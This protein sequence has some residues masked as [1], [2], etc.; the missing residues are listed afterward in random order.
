MWYPGTQVTRR[1]ENCNVTVLQ[2]Y[3]ADPAL[4]SFSQSIGRDFYVDAREDSSSQEAMG[5]PASD[6]R[7]MMDGFVDFINKRVALHLN[8]SVE[9]LPDMLE[10]K[11]M[12]WTVDNPRSQTSSFYLW[13]GGAKWWET[14][15]KSLQPVASEHIHFVGATFSVLQGWGEGALISAEYM[16]QEKM[17]IPAPTWLNR[18]EYCKINP[19]YPERRNNYN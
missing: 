19:F 1:K 3:S 13:K 8:V 2:V 14:F 6:S 16:M 9:D 11:H 5:C 17:K 15:E 7:V 10:V 4:K 18:R 12:S